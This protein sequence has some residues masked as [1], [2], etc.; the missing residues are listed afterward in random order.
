MNRAD[1]GIV[2]GLQAEARWL[3]KA[4]FKIA[5][6]GGTPP[7]AAA[8]ARRLL[9]EGVAA[10]VSF[11]LAGGL[12]PGLRPGAVLVPPLILTESGAYACDS[13]LL[14]FFGGATPGP[15]LGGEEI[16]ATPEAKARLFRQHRADAIDLES[17]AVA[18]IAAAA[19]RPFAALRAVADPAERA[20]PA[21]ALTALRADGGLNLP[22]IA[23]S[24]L[25]RPGQ[26]P[27]LIR[28][29]RDAA[30]A[31]HALAERL[32]ALPRP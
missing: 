29:G 22:G 11:G 12:R 18:E 1:I 14:R 15:I 13:R 8:A 2:T 5:V 3:A 25:R 16:A 17:G 31:R 32:R 23:A 28:T 30:A 6:G 10:L 9:A 4:G 7:G 19:A 21:A 26:I 20:L 24:L 27:D